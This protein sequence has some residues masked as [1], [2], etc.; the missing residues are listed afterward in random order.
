MSTT[1]K[2][3]GIALGVVVLASLLLAGGYVWGRA[4]QFTSGWAGWPGGMMGSFGPGGGTGTYGPGGMMGG[5]G[6]SGMMGG[7]G[8]GGMMG[9]YGSGGMMGGYGSGGMMGSGASGWRSA[10]LEPL[11]IE[12]VEQAVAVYLE[13]SRYTDLE[14]AEVMI[15]D[16]HAYAE[17]I[18]T[19]TG[20]G[21]ME[22]L[23][24]P[25][26]GLVT[27]EHGPNIMWNLKYG[28]MTG[29]MMGMMGPGWTDVDPADM[30]IVPAEAIDLARAYLEQTN[31][32]LEAGSEAEPFYGYYT[33]HTLRDGEP[34]GMLSVHG[35]T[36]DVFLHSWH[37][38]FVEMDE[39]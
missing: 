1:W 37:G 31:S 19:E 22:L 14:L 10:D 17:L 21:A 18:E 3:I 27:P 26:T 32:G 20:Y 11:S 13:Q 15:F 6:P 2:A 35:F 28:P 4:S 7:Y 12:Q 29:G 34:A 23:V 36:G 38:A 25:L 39:H 16:N 5:Y 24:D 8:R 33:I 9:G 30:P